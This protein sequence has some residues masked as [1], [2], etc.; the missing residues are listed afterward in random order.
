MDPTDASI[1]GTKEVAVP[2]TFGVITTAVA[3][4]PLLRGCLGGFRQADSAYRGPGTAILLIESKLIC[5]L[6]ARRINDQM[7]LGASRH[8]ANGLGRG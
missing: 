6:T 3:F 7:H 5:Q 2:V 1:L 4:L 8:V